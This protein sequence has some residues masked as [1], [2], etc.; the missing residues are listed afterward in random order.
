MADAPDP[1]FP[2]SPQDRDIAIRTML[3][4][5]GDP[6]GQAGVASTLINRARA[7][8]YGGK[9]L[10][11]V[12]LAP[13]Q[14]EPWAARPNDLWA[15]PTNDPGYLQAG[16]ILDGVASGALPDPTGGATHFYAPAAQ[17]ALGRN[18]PSWDNG[19]GVA[20]GK[21]LFFAPNGPASSPASQAIAKAGAKL[22]RSRSYRRFW[23]R[24]ACGESI[25]AGRPARRLLHCR[26]ATESRRAGRYGLSRAED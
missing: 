10:S 19:N 15:I 3:G 21:T 6:L 8:G 18:P 2:M 14:F 12:A 22:R 24:C 1:S 16:Q 23:P 5:E 4:E 9:T 26:H 17:K 25:A 7:G 11:S 20:L 13:G